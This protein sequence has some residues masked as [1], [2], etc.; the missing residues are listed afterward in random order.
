MSTLPSLLA[1]SLAASAHGSFIGLTVEEETIDGISVVRLFAQGTDAQDT[2]LSVW[3]VTGATGLNCFHAD[4]ANGSFA[5]QFVTPAFEAIDS[6]VTIGG[7]PGF[8]NTTA[9]DEFWGPPGG[10]GVGIPCGAGWFNSDPTNL[11]GRV[12]PSTLRTLMAQLSFERAVPQFTF[13]AS[14]SFHAGL[15][16]PTHT[17]QLSFTIPGPGGLAALTMTALLSRRSRRVPPTTR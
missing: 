7:S 5:P 10:S 12:D 4:C 11:Q 13:A 6:F 2:L 3:G 9:S 16:T 1:L 17:A 14:V 15:G 8:A